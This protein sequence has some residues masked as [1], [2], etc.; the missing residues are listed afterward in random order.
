[1]LTKSSKDQAYTGDREVVWYIDRALA[2]LIDGTEFWVLLVLGE[3]SRTVLAAVCCRAV[4]G[5]ELSTGLEAAVADYG[6]PRRVV[7][8]VG[9]AIL[10][11][12]IQRWAFEAGV[13]FLISI[14]QS[15]A[16]RGIVETYDRLTS[17][18]LGR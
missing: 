2:H 16:A 6:V 3:A 14:Q 15:H 4:A 11:D 5:Q 18:G 12:D 13:E 9:H 10:D 17:K 8:D 1:M 7:L